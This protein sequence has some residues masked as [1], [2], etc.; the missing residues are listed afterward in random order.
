M[1]QNITTSSDINDMS[2]STVAVQFVNII[3]DLYDYRD[4]IFHYINENKRHERDGIYKD[5][6][7]NS[8]LAEIACDISNYIKDFAA[9]TFQEVIHAKT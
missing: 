5:Q 3:K 8:T 2:I 9:K 6:N 7:W 1:K 4:K